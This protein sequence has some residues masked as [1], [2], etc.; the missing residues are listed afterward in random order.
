MYLNPTC[1]ILGSPPEKLPYG[2]DEQNPHARELRDRMEGELQQAL[3]TG[4]R[5]FYLGMMVGTD[6]AM[7][8]LLLEYQRRCPLRVTAVLACE[9]QANRW[10]DRERERLFRLLSLCDGEVYTA[11]AYSRECY[12]VRN[13]YLTQKGD[14]IVWVY[15]QPPP[16]ALVAR[17]LQVVWIN[18]AT[19]ETWHK[20]PWTQV[21]GRI[22]RQNG[23]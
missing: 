14:V 3:V 1:A 15:N 10:P 7:A 18:P 17:K 9:S 5:E 19:L 2:I 20:V 22:H 11:R 6:L 8:E 12:R 4:I 23:L 13:H 16:A 21:A